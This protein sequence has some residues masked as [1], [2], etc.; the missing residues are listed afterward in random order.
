A[1]SGLGL[2]IARRILELHGSTIEV[3]SAV[4]A[5]TTFTFFLPTQT[6]PRP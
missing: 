2:V 5:G 1:G 3:T 4:N 6:T